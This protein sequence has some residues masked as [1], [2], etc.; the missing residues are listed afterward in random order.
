MMQ[1]PAASRVV[2]GTAV[3]EDED[4]EEAEPTVVAVAPVV[5]GG[6]EVDVTALA[7]WL[8]P[9]P[10]PARSSA[11]DITAVHPAAR[12]GR[13]ERPAPEMRFTAL[14]LALPGSR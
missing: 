4:G 8:L 12:H 13:R 14:L 3:D 11:V 2:V 10:Q 7:A 6:A 9:E 5:G 1:T